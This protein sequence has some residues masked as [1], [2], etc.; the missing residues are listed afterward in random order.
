MATTNDNPALLDEGDVATDNTNLEVRVKNGVKAWR[1]IV[2]TNVLTRIT[3]VEN[4]GVFPTIADAPVPD[5][6]QDQ[7]EVDGR[8]YRAKQDLSGYEIDPDVK[9]V[10]TDADKDALVYNEAEY[11]AKIPVLYRDPDG[12][13]QSYR[14][15][16]SVDFDTWN[17]LPTNFDNRFEM[18][19]SVA[20]S[21]VSMLHL[22]QT[23]PIFNYSDYVAEQKIPYRHLLH[24]TNTSREFGRTINLDGARALQYK[25]GNFP[26]SE[27]ANSTGFSI[28]PNAQATLSYD[29]DTV[30]CSVQTSRDMGYYDNISSLT[31][32]NS[33]ALNKG[34]F[35]DVGDERYFWDSTATEGVTPDNNP[36]VGRWVQGISEINYTELQLG[37]LNVANTYFATAPAGVSNEIEGV[38]YLVKLPADTTPPSPMT[39]AWWDDE[40]PNMIVVG[41]YKGGIDELPLGETV[42]AGYYYAIAPLNTFDEVA[43]ARYEVYLPNEV[44]VPDPM[45]SAI[46]NSNSLEVIGRVKPIAQW[47]Q[48]LDGSGL[49]AFS[50]IADLTNDNDSYLNVWT[51][52]APQ[53]LS[54]VMAPANINWIDLTGQS[55]AFDDS[56]GNQRQ[57]TLPEKTRMMVKR[58]GGIAHVTLTDIGATSSTSRTFDTLGDTDNETFAD[59]E[60]IFISDEQAKYVF[61]EG[62][63]TGDYSIADAVTGYLNRIGQ[64]IHTETLPAD[65]G[66]TE[67]LSFNV[68][69]ASYGDGTLDMPPTHSTYYIRRNDASTAPLNIDQPA[70]T[71]AA[72]DYKWHK[73][74]RIDA[75]TVTKIGSSDA[76]YSGLQV[77]KKHE[78]N[79]QDVGSGSTWV[80]HVFGVDLRTVDL[81]ELEISDSA[82][83]H[84]KVEQA[85][86]N[87]RNADGT[88]KDF[89]FQWHDAGYI[90]GSVVNAET[91]EVE[92]IG[93]NNGTRKLWTARLLAYAENGFVVPEG[94]E[95]ATPRTITLAGGAGTIGGSATATAYEGIP[96]VLNLD[97]NPN[98]QISNNPTIDVGTVDIVDPVNGTVLVNAGSDDAVI[99]ITE[100]QAAGF[101]G[102]LKIREVKDVSHP[103][104]NSSVIDMG[105]ELQEGDLIE[106]IHQYATLSERA[107]VW[108][109]VEAGTR[110]RHAVYPNTNEIVTSEFPATLDNNVTWD[111]VAAGN[112]QTKLV[113]W[114]IWRDAALG[115]VI[116]TGTEIITPRTLTV[117]TPSGTETYTVY[118]ELSWLIKLQ[119]TGGQAFVEA[120]QF[121]DADAHA[122]SCH[123]NLSAE[124]ELVIQSDGADCSITLTETPALAD[125]TYT[126][127]NT[128]DNEEHTFAELPNLL[129]M[130][131]S[132]HRQVTL[133][134]V[135]G[136]DETLTDA[137]SYWHQTSA[138]MTAP[139]ERTFNAVVKN[140]AWFNVDFSQGGAF[141]VTSFTYKGRLWRLRTVVAHAWNGNLWELE[142]WVI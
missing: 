15:I 141:E 100:T 59:N 16:V 89:Y 1:R 104:L 9:A 25:R 103:I 142:S 108:A 98:R 132:T 47:L 125:Y 93:I 55:I 54:L 41:R 112:N 37:A 116:P 68:L 69:D 64:G 21:P 3:S 57:F 96:T 105:I 130:F 99:T 74:I 73:F 22:A 5:G 14:P 107:T 32:I 97:L 6:P 48:Y 67:T 65:G 119:P 4:I 88:R 26:P 109:R 12:K 29:A 62:A 77:V 8:V 135:D 10:V 86:A 94:F 20:Q 101:N 27:G 31:A 95:L 127:V 63:T 102:L 126:R 19:G 111:T 82:G 114:R 66:A 40:A 128:N 79:G 75:E 80:S 124:G 133:T 90:R 2:V 137:L 134:T 33:N 87:A 123:G 39:V 61:N 118:D 120:G 56:A 84:T 51:G 139:S 43:G 121:T 122:A 7:I 13:L 50:P 53:N 60:I 92:F 45:D 58:V 42:P 129:F 131:G 85:P 140:L 136:T 70:M 38:Q 138:N 11:S 30:Y 17:A 78:F 83:S 24:I 52:E 115:F 18:I 49:R 71:I 28:P 34:D 106:A 113:G 46:W 72:N 44:A 23:D 76:T 110:T 36:P 117:N 81:I 91:G 35:S